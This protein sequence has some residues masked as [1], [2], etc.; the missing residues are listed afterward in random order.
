MILTKDILV[1]GTETFF[2][3]RPKWLLVLPNGQDNRG[4]ENYCGDKADEHMSPAQLLANRLLM[5]QEKPIRFRFFT[6]W[7][8]TTYPKP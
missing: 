3:N 8:K 1:E 6:C 2:V 4:S 7:F 5:R